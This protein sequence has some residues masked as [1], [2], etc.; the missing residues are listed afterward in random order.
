M[1]LIIL[2]ARKYPWQSAIMLLALLLAGIAEGFGL[3]ALLPLIST[4]TS[5]QI[6]AG[7]GGSPSSSSLESAVT[8]SLTAL[9]LTPSIGVLLVLIVFAI[10]L[11]SLLVLL[12]KKR[13][14]Y[15]V[16]RVATDLRL[17]LLVEAHCFFCTPQ[18]DD[19]GHVDEEVG[20]I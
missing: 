1:R 2:F 12:A 19:G 9:G 7:K 4:V 18:H 13:V 5:G 11:K 10:V 8:D 6:G 20:S 16:A 17:E 15:T 14:G 3:S